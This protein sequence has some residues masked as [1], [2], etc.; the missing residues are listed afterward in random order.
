[1]SKAKKMKTSTMND[2]ELLNRMLELTDRITSDGLPHNPGWMFLM[3]TRPAIQQL[4][5]D[6]FIV[7]MAAASLTEH[8][9][10]G[11]QASYEQILQRAATIKDMV[12]LIK[13]VGAQRIARMLKA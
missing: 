1:M 12:A 2:N 8:P 3:S 13:Q 5:S 6:G 7:A 4:G 9:T 10:E 11:C